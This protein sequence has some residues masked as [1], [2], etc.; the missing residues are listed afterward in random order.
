[1]GS[2]S[3]LLSALVVVTCATLLSAG[4]ALGLPPTVD[5]GAAGIANED[6]CKALATYVAGLTDET[7]G[8]PVTK[9]TATWKTS[10]S[11]P[12]SG[13][14]F[15][16]VT[17]WIWPETKFEVS[18]PTVWNERYYMKGVAAGTGT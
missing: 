15:C 8:K 18:M 7:F 4:S 12:T 2:R 14:T 17:G 3:I 1:M 6:N 10:T 11:G 13:Q 9:T 5:Y 16:Q